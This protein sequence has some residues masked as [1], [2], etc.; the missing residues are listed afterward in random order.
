MQT[1][2]IFCGT[3]NVNGK[4][5]ED[6]YGLGNWINCGLDPVP[7]MLVIG[8]QEMVDLSAVN[9]MMESATDGKAKGNMDKWSN[10]MRIAI[11][12]QG[13]AC[14]KRYELV[15]AKH[16]VGICLLVFASDELI[17][18]IS[19]IQKSIVPT[20]A[21]GLG[22]KGGVCIRADI[23]DTQVAFVSSHLYAHRSKVAERNGDFQNIA[24]KKIFRNM[25]LRPGNL[26]NSLSS[27]IL[28]KEGLPGEKDKAQPRGVFGNL[29]AFQGAVS[30]SV[31]STGDREEKA[32]GGSVDGASS[33]LNG[34]LEED[35]QCVLDHDLVFWMGDLNYRIVEG[36]ELDE[37]YQLI[38]SGDDGLEK[39]IELDQLNQERSAGRSF[40]GFHEGRLR[41][42]PTYKYIPGEKPQRYDN[43]PEKKMRCPSWCDRVLWRQPPGTMVSYDQFASVDPRPVRETNEAFRESVQLLQ[44]RAVMGLAISDHVPVNAVF[45]AKV[46]KIDQQRRL[47]VCR[48]IISERARSECRT[49]PLLRPSERAM[50]FSDVRYEQDQ[51]RSLMLHAEIPSLAAIV[52]GRDQAADGAPDVPFR[53]SSNSVPAWLRLSPMEGVVPAGGS[54]TITVEC[55]S[56]VAVGNVSR[57]GADILSAMLVIF[58]DGGE[59]R[60]LPVTAFL[61]KQE[62]YAAL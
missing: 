24:T 37:V 16:M 54:L 42:G 7:D 57:L 17:P 18:H 27:P 58:V 1:V 15:A 60:V 36:V 35:M 30:A 31:D 48:E 10:V 25:V 44:Y 47:E 62:V 39:L 45:D 6:Y 38:N 19:G 41:F 3:W 56:S 14:G 13:G 26:S 12:R 50:W 8:L 32:E 21:G 34:N 33:G 55:L 61:A 20:G 9:V 23:Y 4:V 22:N 11:A 40:R 51:Q 43:R 53:I 29:L 49:I 2:R 59:D 46:R 5:E 52:G 28:S